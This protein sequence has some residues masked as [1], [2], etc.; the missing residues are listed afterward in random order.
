MFKTKN[1]FN[2][3]VKNDSKSMAGLFP[4]GI[5]S[6]KEIAEPYIGGYSYILFTRI[7]KQIKGATTYSQKDAKIDFV[8]PQSDFF[9]LVERQFKE[10]SGINDIDMETVSIQSGFTNNEHRYPGGISKNTNEITLKLNEMSGGL[11]RRPIQ[12]WM[13]GIR[14]PETGLYT[15][16]EKGFK[17]YTVE[18][19]YVNCAPSVG[20]PS[21]KSRGESL[22][23]AAYFTGLFPTRNTLS[24][25]NY[26]SASHDIAEFDIPFPCNMHMGDKIEEFGRQFISS[27][28]F[29]EDFIQKPHEVITDTL[30]AKGENEAAEYF[31]MDNDIDE[32][33]KKP[34]KS[35]AFESQD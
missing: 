25:L 35:S 34:F 8:S 11:I 21:A 24:H 5:G 6:I 30:L 12:Q 31:T 33:T 16:P 7:P 1:N 14:D 19:L 22:E 18:F 20:S 2:E 28:K 27:Q 15:F 9:K 3:K 32:G 23:F 10:L 17:N 13:T 26:A 29:F 4:G